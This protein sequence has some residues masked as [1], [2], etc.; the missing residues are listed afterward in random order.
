MAS[1]AIQTLIRTLA[2]PQGRVRPDL[3]SFAAERYPLLRQPGYPSTTICAL[4]RRPWDTS[5][6][7]THGSPVGRA[8]PADGLCGGLDPPYPAGRMSL[9]ADI[10]AD[11]AL[12]NPPRVWPV[13]LADSSSLQR[14]SLS[15]PQP[16]PHGRGSFGVAPALLRRMLDAGGGA[17]SVRQASMISLAPPVSRPSSTAG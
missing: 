14:A 8:L 5:R 15:L 10:M 6:G 3:A 4:G 1:V 2:S 7:R 17:H 11:R 16:L 13:Y 9:G 12:H